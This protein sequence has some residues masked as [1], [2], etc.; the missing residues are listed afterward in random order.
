MKTRQQYTVV[1]LIVITLWK[2][3]FIDNNV[4]Q[5][6]VKFK[7]SVTLLLFAR[8]QLNFKLTPPSN[9]RCPRITKN[10][11]NAAE[12]NRINTV[13]PMNTAQ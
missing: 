5:L 3:A 1:H 9:K 4:F 10:L 13:C 7:C 6:E 2:F 11:I 8:N 12:F